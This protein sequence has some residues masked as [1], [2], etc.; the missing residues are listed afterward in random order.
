M[1][2]VSMSPWRPA[3]RARD[4]VH[5]ALLCT[6]VAACT[7]PGT[8]T[9]TRA[10][11]YPTLRPGDPRIAVGR[12]AGRECFEY[13]AI[14]ADD[15]TRRVLGPL[16]V[17]WGQESAGR[18]R[19]AWVRSAYARQTEDTMVYDARSL[20][21]SRERLRVGDQVITLRY[22][23]ATVE[24]SV[25]RGDSLG[26]VHSV[27][28]DRPVFGFN[29]REELLRVTRLQPGDTLILPLY[30]EIDA[31]LELDT[32]SLVA[33]DPSTGP[34][35]AIHLRFADP[36]IVATVTVDTLTSR[37]LDELI[38]NRRRPGHLTRTLLA[39]S[40]TCGA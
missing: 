1:S 22:R 8:P 30:S 35:G 26:P 12:P 9:P 20:A 13:A 24:R 19:G 6:L 17:V 4:L 5:A 25:Q 11:R 38:Q 28:F 7:S 15:T 32:I 27:T 29:Q 34:T 37:I 16:A 2:F 33:A 14:G 31:A 23:G 39:S 40:Q 3:L 10:E 36:A 21:P 18:G